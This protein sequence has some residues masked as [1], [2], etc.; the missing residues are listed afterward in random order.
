MMAFLFDETQILEC[1]KLNKSLLDIQNRTLDP[2]N[3]KTVSIKR[4]LAA[5]YSGAH[6]IL[7]R[8]IGIN[9]LI[10]YCLSIVTCTICG[11]LLKPS[12]LASHQ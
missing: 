3:L 1:Q 10:L 7:T 6:D 2:D 8:E 11:L 4:G 9:V 12:Q 5:T